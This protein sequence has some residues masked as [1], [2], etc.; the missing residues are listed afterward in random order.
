MVVMQLSSV[1]WSSMFKFQRQDLDWCLL[2]MLVL[3]SS[4]QNDQLMML[5]DS[6]RN[7]VMMMIR[8][9]GFGQD[10]V[11]RLI[12]GNSMYVFYCYECMFGFQ[13]KVLCKLIVQMM[14]SVMLVV[15]GMV[16]KLSRKVNCVLVLLSSGMSVVESLVVVVGSLLLLQSVL[17]KIEIMMKQMSRNGSV[18]LV[19]RLVCVRF[20]WCGF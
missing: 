6:V 2:S 19:K 17:V 14:L 16:R 18:R 7:V 10:D 8:S 5:F 9:S 20:L 15:I 3:L 4:R 12:C 11:I 1:I 13:L